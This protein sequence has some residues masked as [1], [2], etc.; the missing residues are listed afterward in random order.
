LAAPFG[1]KGSKSRL[2]D[3]LHCACEFYT[4]TPLE[5]RGVSDVGRGWPG[6]ADAGL[7]WPRLARGFFQCAS[8]GYPMLA[9]YGEI[10][11]IGIS[12]SSAG[13]LFSN[14]FQP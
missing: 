10:V 2:V 8:G 7:G 6:L 1:E 13:I 4:R 12:G 5:L 9:A 3:S 11:A 14:P